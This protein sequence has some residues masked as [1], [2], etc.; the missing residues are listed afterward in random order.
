MKSGLK[1]PKLPASFSNLFAS[2]SIKIFLGRLDAGLIV[3]A[4]EDILFLLYYSALLKS[5]TDLPKSAFFSI[6]VLC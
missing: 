6:I 2:I 5:T 1:K 4:S 3:I